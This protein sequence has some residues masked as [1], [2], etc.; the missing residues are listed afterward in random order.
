[1]QALGARDTLGNSPDARVRAGPEVIDCV[2][3]ANVKLSDR[4]LVSILAMVLTDGDE[5]GWQ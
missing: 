2:G 1:M 4:L 3:E 5:P